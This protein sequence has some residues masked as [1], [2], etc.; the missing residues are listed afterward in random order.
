MCSSVIEYLPAYVR[1]GLYSKNHKQNKLSQSTDFTSEE[2]L[3]NNKKTLSRE[4]EKQVMWMGYYPLLVTPRKGCDEGNFT[5]RSSC[6]M[7]KQIT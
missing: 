7:E 1:P 5:I 3:R 6:L 2:V 4:G